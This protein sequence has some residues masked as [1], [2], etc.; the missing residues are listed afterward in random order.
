MS[1]PSDPRL[2]REYPRWNETLRDRT[3]VLIRPMLPQDRDAEK[4]FIETLSSRARRFRFMGAISAPG[5]KL[6]DQMTRVDTAHEAAFA[7]VIPEDGHERIIGVSRY[8]TDAGD[9]RCECAVTVLDE[10]QGKGLGTLLMRHLIEVARSHGIKVM[11]S[12]DSAENVEMTDLAEFLGF[13][14]RGD[15][16]DASQVIHERVL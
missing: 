3:H 11:Y 4:R 2:D 9:R 16:D 12:V 13:T 1:H 14:T 8:A 6:L 10:W 5:E 15:P 7:A